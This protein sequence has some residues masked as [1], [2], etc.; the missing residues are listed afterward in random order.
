M[1]ATKGLIDGS[2]LE[3]YERIYYYCH[4]II[5][6]NLSSTAKVNVQHVPDN[7]V[8]K[9]P[10]FQRLYICYATCKESFKLCDL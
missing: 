2:L 3:Q 1:C 4:E 6:T 8:D 7:A 5:K 9:M 10:H